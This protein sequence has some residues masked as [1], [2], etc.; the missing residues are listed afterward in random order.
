MEL[1]RQGHLTKPAG[2]TGNC[3][4]RKRSAHNDSGAE[5]IR[6][7]NKLSEL[8]TSKAVPLGNSETGRAWCVKALHPA[9]PLCD[10]R[11]LPDQSAVPSVF[12]AYSKQI[13]ISNPTA[14]T[15]GI[16]SAEVFLTAHPLI[17]A[18]ICT[19]DSSGA[20]AWSYVLNESFGSSGD[21][22]ATRR[23][24]F[25]TQVERYRLA[26]LSVTGHLDAAAVTDQGMLAVAQYPIESLECTLD[27]STVAPGFLQRT[28]CAFNEGPKTYTQLM[29]MPNAYTANARDGCYAV[30][31][32]SHTHQ[33]WRNA[34]MVRPHLPYGAASVFTASSEGMN[35]P[36]AAPS[37]TTATGL[38]P[39]GLT[40]MYTGGSHTTSIVHDRMDDGVI[41]VSF[42]NLHYLSSFVLTFRMGMELQVSPGSPLVP[43]LKASPVYDPQAIAAYF[44]ISRE[45][46]D[47]YPENYNSG[48]KLGAVLW[49]LA[50]GLLSFVP[51]GNQ[52]SG[53]AEGLYHSIKGKKSEPYEKM[54]LAEIED[55]QTAIRE[56]DAKA[57]KQ[58]K[59]SDLNR[60]RRE[61]KRPNQKSSDRI[62]R[63]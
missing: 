49:Q 23:D 29:T 55:R 42:Q 3:K 52:I 18:A 28:C 5:C 22:M 27:V 47:A 37:T 38:F 33:V 7:A 25:A 53:L 16:W 12:Q 15:A 34:R 19:Y 61:G 2:S 1:A 10:V 35:K 32:L 26:Y 51:G 14:G 48:G 46:K 8:L 21:T 58:G 9:D 45:L 40:G 20:Y 6:V 44:Q 57:S 59:N 63:K 30:Y 17:I 36:V 4:F 31:R 41:H 54:S 56:K 50:R 11:G 60:F 43:F 24:L 39:Y 13:S 62:T